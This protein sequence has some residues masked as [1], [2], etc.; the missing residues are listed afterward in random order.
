MGLPEYIRQSIDLNKYYFILGQTLDKDKKLPK[1]SFI[2]FKQGPTTLCALI[3]NVET[4]Q[5]DIHTEE[6]VVVEQNFLD[7]LV[8]T[9]QSVGRDVWMTEIGRRMSYPEPLEELFKIGLN[10]IQ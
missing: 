8:S 3:Y 2:S 9:L 10:H 5:T 6:G 1:T 7:Y 4:G